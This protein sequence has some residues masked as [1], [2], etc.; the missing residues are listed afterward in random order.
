MAW[1]VLDLFFPKLCI[2][3]LADVDLDMLAERGINAVILDL[4]NTILPWRDHHVP[5]KS[6]DWI[7]RAMERGI[8]LCIASNT[9]NPRRLRIVAEGLGIQAFDK[10]AKPRRS[11]LRR[12]MD[13]MEST[14]ETTAIIGD[15]IFTD[16][17]GG[18]R[19][20]ILT[21]LVQPMHHREFVGTKI[22]RLFEKPFLAALARRG[23][24]GTKGTDKASDIQD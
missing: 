16:I 8:K 24:L 20:T 5:P 10:A 3:S 2:P 4:D 6:E 19:L 12:A 13:I 11:G 15:Q 23:M 17:V 22:S 9:R 1:K 14:I 18:N 7:K 21:I